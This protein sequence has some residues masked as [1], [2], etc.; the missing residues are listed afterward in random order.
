VSNSL[1]CLYRACTYVV[2][3]KTDYTQTTIHA[4]SKAIWRECPE[5]AEGQGRSQE[6]FAD[7]SGLHRADVGAIERGERNVTLR[8]M[9]IIADTLGVRLRI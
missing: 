9:R 1:L 4:R 3:I 7:R 2:V 8:T 6:V 5:S